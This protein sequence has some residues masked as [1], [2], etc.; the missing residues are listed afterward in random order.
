MNLKMKNDKTIK[1]KF[2]AASQKQIADEG[3]HRQ[4]ASFVF[5]F[6]FAVVAYDKVNGRCM[7]EDC[8]TFVLNPHSGPFYG[9]KNETAFEADAVL[10]RAIPASIRLSA[11]YSRFGSLSL[12]I[13]ASLI[14]VLCGSMKRG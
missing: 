9:L 1:Y 12:R 10:Q 5:A 3:R 13:T 4:N 7:P 8:V 11:G 14:R 2:A 6:N